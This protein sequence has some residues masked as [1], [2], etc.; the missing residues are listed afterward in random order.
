MR[1]ISFIRNLKQNTSTGPSQP[2]PHANCIQ[3][4]YSHKTTFGPGSISF[5][6]SVVFP[7]GLTCALRHRAATLRRGKDLLPT[8]DTLQEY[9]TFV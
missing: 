7:W 3:A 2:Q 5:L 1:K 6:I 8:E 9:E 4:L